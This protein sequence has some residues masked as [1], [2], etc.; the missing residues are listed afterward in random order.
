MNYNAWRDKSLPSP[1][2]D[3][4]ILQVSSYESTEWLIVDCYRKL[5]EEC[6]KRLKRVLWV[7]LDLFKAKDNDLGTGVR[8][9][10]GKWPSI[11]SVSVVYA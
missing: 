5:W 2:Y 11:R 7:Y 3:N 9:P 1:A 10:C 4:L 6:H 8:Q